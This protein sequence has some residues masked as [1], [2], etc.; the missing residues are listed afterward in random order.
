MTE[1]QF[2]FT[3]EDN[4]K[5]IPKP[6]SG[7]Y[8]LVNILIEADS[9]DGLTDAIRKMSIYFRFDFGSTYHNFSVSYQLSKYVLAMDSLIYTIEFDE[10]V[11][12]ITSEKTCTNAIVSIIDNVLAPVS[13]LTL[14]LRNF[15]SE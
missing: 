11:L 5:E 2:E 9:L 14:T 7:K 4:V 13:K 8:E 1:I 3:P 10:K 15:E 6:I 12:E